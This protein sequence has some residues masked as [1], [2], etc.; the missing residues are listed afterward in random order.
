MAQGSSGFRV[1]GVP[2]PIPLGGRILLA[3]ICA[4][5][6]ASCMDYYTLDLPDINLD[7]PD[8]LPQ[9]LAA[10][11]SG[12]EKWRG[13]PRAVADMAIRRYVDVPWSP[14]PFRPSQYQV[15]ESADWGTY[16]VR[17]YVYPSGNLTRYRVKVRPYQ[18]IW[19]PVQISRY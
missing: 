17:G 10:F 16:V 4:L 5:G 9:R 8:D 15:L 19:Y 18:D 2:R 3:A 1:E 12:A 11:R 13:D 14:E 6:T 7:Q